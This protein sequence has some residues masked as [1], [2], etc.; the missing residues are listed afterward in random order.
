MSTYTLMKDLTV[1]NVQSWMVQGTKA[2]QSQSAQLR[3]W[4]RPDLDP[5]SK[6]S[7][8]LAGED[9]DR[10]MNEIGTA[11]V[12]AR[13][14]LNGFA[15]EAYFA[16]LQSVF[17]NTWPALKGKGAGVSVRYLSCRLD[18]EGEPMKSGIKPTKAYLGAPSVSAGRIGI[19]KA[20]DPT[21]AHYAFIAWKQGV[22]ADI[23]DP[24]GE[25]TAVPGGDL[26]GNSPE[27][28]EA[29]KDHESQY[30]PS[31]APRSSTDDGTRYSRDAVLTIAREQ[32]GQGRL[33]AETEL[34]SHRK[35]AVLAAFMIANC[36]GEVAAMLKTAAMVR[37]GLVETPSLV[38]TP[39]VAATVAKAPRKPRARKPQV[40]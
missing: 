4:A 10:A 27:R 24:I 34:A 1:E 9:L 38:E 11:I 22:T 3:Y 30:Q 16:S 40:V 32:R 15:T 17:R 35:N 31:P 13:V 28:S 21:M 2:L 36:H 33:D 14:G 19:T 37:F 26:F 20:G 5:E 8:N 6:A 18:S 12:L 25:I 39:A 29:E 23:L 7:R